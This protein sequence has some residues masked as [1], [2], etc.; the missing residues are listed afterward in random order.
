MPAGDYLDFELNIDILSP[1]RL[2]VTVVNSPAGSV[3]VEVAYTLTEAEI[4]EVIGVLDGSNPKISRGAAAKVARTFGEKLFGL[5]FTGRVYTAYFNSLK[6][7]GERGLRI[8]LG[9]ENAKSLELLPWELMRDPNSDYL[10]LSRQTPLVRYPRLLTVR[11]L[12]EVTLPLRVLVLIST[13]KDLDKLDVEA[14]WQA[15]VTATNDLRARGLLELVRVDD[16][17]LSALQRKLR[18]RTAF[19]VFHFIGHAAFDERSQA[20]MLAFEDAGSGEAVPVSAEALAR[21]LSEENS[22]RL[23]VINACQGARSN[24][25]DPFAGVASSIVTRGIPSVVAMQFEIS[26][27]ASRLFAGEFYR[28]L[29]EGYPIEAAVAEGRRA[30]SSGMNTLEWVTP[31]LYLRAASGVLFP[32]RMDS[33]VTVGGGVRDVLM[34]A[35]ILALLGVMGIVAVAVFILAAGR[36]PADTPTPTANVNVATLTPTPPGGKIDVDLVVSSVRFLPPNPNP[37]QQA[38]IAIK[39]E[40]RGKT[41]SGKFSW[42][43]FATNPQTNPEPTL[44]GE[45]LNLSPGLSTTV[46]TNYRFSWWGT[47]TT[48]AWVNFDNAI[49][50]TNIFNNFQ[51]RTVELGKEAFV[52]DFANAPNGDL[53]EP[54]VLPAAVFERWGILPRAQGEGACAAAVVRA[55]ISARDVPRLVVGTAEGT[56]GCETTPLEFLLNAVEDTPSIIAVTVAFAPVAAGEYA[57]EMLGGDGSVTSRQ[58]VQVEAGG[59]NPDGENTVTI[60]APAGQLDL[61]RLV[62]RPPAGA[63][64]VVLS[65]TRVIQ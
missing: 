47:F 60:S 20:G 38:T 23:V 32:K 1:E 27:T 53:I 7:A 29:S 65:L 43:W 62:F 13:P 14:E 36:T 22:I 12:V 41:D 59:V 34:R 26:D 44:R 4:A 25:D 42:V 45:V 39:I 55:A 46:I 8:K 31:V 49:P 5:I 16:A 21:E 37:G 9:L 48:T 2:R 56:P 19:Q 18:E 40:N 15:L 54:G 52:V 3:A 35:P 57:L 61:A 6:E 50:E 24:Q 63:A 30:I 11:P 10:V 28:A 17:N 51:N 33:G 64:A 58:T